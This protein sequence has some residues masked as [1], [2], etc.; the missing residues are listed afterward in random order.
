MSD[1]HPNPCGRLFTSAEVAAA[2][3]LGIET[4]PGPTLRGP[5]IYRSGTAI[6]WWPNEL[7]KEAEDRLMVAAAIEREFTKP[8]LDQEAE[9]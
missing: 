7:R 6:N 5:L 9:R 4:G 8:M 3:R 2:K 1:I